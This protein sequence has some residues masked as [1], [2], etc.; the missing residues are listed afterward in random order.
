MSSEAETQPQQTQAEEG[1]PKDLFEDISPDNVFSEIESLCMNCHEQGTTRLLL[2]RVPFFREIIVMAFSCPH[3]G[4][5]SNEI[6]S[7]STIQEKGVKHVLNVKS[8]KDLNRQVIKSDTGVITLPELEFEIPAITQKGSLNTIEGILMQSVTALKNG[9]EERQKIDA[10]VAEQVGKFIDRLE[11]CI[12][13]DEPIFTFILDDPS[14]NSFVENPYVPQDDPNLKVS[15]YERTTEQNLSIGLT[16]HMD[17]DAEEEDGKQAMIFPGT[18]SNC[19]A[20]GETK[21]VVTDIPYFKE[22]VLMAFTCDECGFKSN[23]VKCGGAVSEKARKITF[24]ATTP[25]DLTRDILKS[26]TAS[27]FFPEFDVELGMGTL[28]GRFTTIDG[29]LTQLKSEFES[30]P[31]LHGDSANNTQKLHIERVFT[32]IANA[33]AGQPFTI[34]IDDPLANSYIQNFYAPDADPNLTIEDYDRTFDQNEELGLNDMKTEN[35]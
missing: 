22:I 1:Q 3:C 21:M 12:T 5:E 7:G 23:E 30:T 32:G 6:Q 24:K 2:T 27:V 13:T 18:C 28:G 11:S 35:Y 25:E 33:L 4:Y 15:H 17:P 9:Q 26:E 19:N 29:L 8:R 10:A 14:G 31:F 16:P 34:I 20:E